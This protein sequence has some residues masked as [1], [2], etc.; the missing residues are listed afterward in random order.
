[1]TSLVFDQVAPEFVLVGECTRQ[2]HSPSLPHDLHRVEQCHD[3][4]DLVR[5]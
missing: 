1:M 5:V 2:L 4:L 3:D